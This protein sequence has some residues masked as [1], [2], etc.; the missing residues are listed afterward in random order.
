MNRILFAVMMIFLGGCVSA[1]PD[2]L[3]SQPPMGIYEFD[4]PM[5]AAL[6][7]IAQGA[8]EDGPASVEYIDTHL[9]R[10]V[11][12][13]KNIYGQR[14]VL[15]VAKAEP[16]ETGTRI[17]VWSDPRYNVKGALPDRLW[18]GMETVPNRQGVTHR[19]IQMGN[20]KPPLPPTESR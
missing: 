10:V 12:S 4:L 15:M 20:G 8:E 9:S 17:L 5:D 14:Y 3:S 6:S 13:E 7:T 16:I 2:E 1:T 19:V 11:M 18:G